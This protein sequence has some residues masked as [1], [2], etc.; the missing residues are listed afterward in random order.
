MSYKVKDH[1]YH[2]AKEENFKARSV[3]KLQEI[4]QRWKL[5]KPGQVL[6]DLGASPGSWTQYLSQKIGTKGRLFA[7]DLTPVDV[8]SLSLK[9]DNVEFAQGDAFDFDFQSHFQKFGWTAPV[10]GVLS[11]MAPKTTGIRSVDQDRSAELCKSSLQTA[12]KYL[13]PG[14]FFICKLFFSNN[15]K[16][17]AGE[18]KKSFAKLEVIKP[19]STRKESTEVFLVGL[20]YK[21]H[22]R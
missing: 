18:I 6:I 7:I 11:D 14:G 5:V 19:D 20:S 2:R 12:Q 4:D 16:E 9:Y 8:S 13:A 21:G 15:Y 17:I 1:Y 10:S 3:Y 22:A